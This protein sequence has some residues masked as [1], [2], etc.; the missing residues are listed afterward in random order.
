MLDSLYTTFVDMFNFNSN[1]FTL[2]EI[3]ATMLTT[4]FGVCLALFPLW[5]FK[6]F[7]Y[8]IGGK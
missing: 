1:F 3:V 2:T 5:L 6:F 8:L 4:F 7:M